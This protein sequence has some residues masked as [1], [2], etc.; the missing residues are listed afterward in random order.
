MWSPECHVSHV[1]EPG[2]RDIRHLCTRIELAAR[3]LEE[4]AMLARQASYQGTSTPH[5]LRPDGKLRDAI[6]A[7]EQLIL[8]FPE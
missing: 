4:Q 6:D 7:M 5:L 8:H 2:C 1:A 3:E